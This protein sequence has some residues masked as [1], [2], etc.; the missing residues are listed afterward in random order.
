MTLEYSID[1]DHSVWM[2]VPL[3]FPWNGYPDADEWS[4]DL[5]SSLLEGFDVPDEVM[6]ALTE[7]A[8]ANAKTDGP[9]PGANERF[10]HFPLDGGT[11][12]LVHLYVN[13]YEHAGEG[14]WRALATAWIGGY[15]QVLEPLA[16]TDFDEAVR[17]VVIAQEGAA[18]PIYVVRF[19]GLR[20]GM[21]FILEFVEPDSGI[22]AELGDPAEAL[23]RAIR[24][25]D[26]P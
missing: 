22:V 24:V 4:R 2:P 21:A 3:D 11:Q 8:R 7:S 20:A 9:F 17:S 18:E 19:I 1:L 13:D 16:D 5:A 6:A 14:A 25:R 15:V 23:F 12:R 26:A 10:W